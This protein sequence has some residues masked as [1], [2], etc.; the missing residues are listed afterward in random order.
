MEFGFDECCGGKGQKK[1]T[2]NKT[3]VMI[4]SRE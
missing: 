4:S 3:S 2:E 1:L